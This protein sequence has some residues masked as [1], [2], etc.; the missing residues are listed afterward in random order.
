MKQ[1]LQILKLIVSLLPAI[2]E[3]VK[4]IEAQVPIPG[5]G[6]AKLDLLKDIVTDAYEGLTPDE[7]QGLSLE[8]VVGVIAKVA[9][10]VVKLFNKTGWSA[11]SATVGHG[12]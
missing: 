11:T 4:A 8:T 3:L 1:L 5:V 6:P 7:Q 2:V 10:G 12:G 9:S